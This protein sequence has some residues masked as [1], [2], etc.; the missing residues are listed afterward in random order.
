MT[1]ETAIVVAAVVLVFTA[2]AVALAWAEHQTRTI[3]R[4]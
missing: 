2:F 3:R 1:A 4:P